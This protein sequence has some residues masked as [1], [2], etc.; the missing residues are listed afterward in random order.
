MDVDST[1]KSMV[2][3]FALIASVSSSLAQ[4]VRVFDVQLVVRDS[5][6][7][8]VKRNDMEIQ[9]VNLDTKLSEKC[10]LLFHSE[11]DIPRIELIRGDYVLI[12]EQFANEEGR[13]RARLTGITIA[14]EGQVRISPKTQSPSAC[15]S[16]ERKDFEILRSRTLS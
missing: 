7:I 5:C 15:G 3:S 13:C 14:R 8:L 9:N 10:R 16:G 11:T 2:F 12:I 1:M 4:D 6:E